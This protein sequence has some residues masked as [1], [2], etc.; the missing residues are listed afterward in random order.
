MA[1][2]EEGLTSCSEPKAMRP[3]FPGTP[4]GL[5]EAA[6]PQSAGL[7]TRSIPPTRASQ[8]RPGWGHRG[9]RPRAPSCGERGRTRWAWSCGRGLTY[10][11]GQR[12]GPALVLVSWVPVTLGSPAAGR[13][14]GVTGLLFRAPRSGPG[15]VPSAGAWGGMPGRPPTLRTPSCSS[16]ARN[17][18]SY[19]RLHPPLRLLA[20]SQQ[21]QRPQPR[22][23]SSLQPGLPTLSPLPPIRP[24]TLVHITPS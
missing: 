2:C 11:A 9:R 8:A 19:P 5:A 20:L 17:Q 23:P 16:S 10:C 12:S 24:S 13:C 22:S 3:S 1:G 7:R 18:V 6:G 15:N 14:A 21:S 4:Q